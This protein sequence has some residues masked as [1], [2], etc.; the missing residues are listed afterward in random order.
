M[1]N[2]NYVPILL[3][4]LFMILSFD[5]NENANDWIYARTTI[6]VFVNNVECARTKTAA[7]TDD[8]GLNE[9]KI[10]EDSNKKRRNISAFRNYEKEARQ[11]D[12][13]TGHSLT[14]FLEKVNSMT[15]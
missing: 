1:L 13:T 8:V 7:A 9:M 5:R 15:Q 10:K 2:T 3:R 12:I 6:S 14:S 4:A 11:R